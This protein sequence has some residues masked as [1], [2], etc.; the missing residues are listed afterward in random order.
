MKA[1]SKTSLLQHILLVGILQVLFACAS[2]HLFQQWDTRLK[3]M[4]EAP[5]K[6]NRFYTQQ[7][8]SLLLGS[9]PMKC[10]RLPSATPK[11]GIYLAGDQPTIKFVVPDSPASAAGIEPG[12]VVRSVNG[13]PTT[14]GQAVIKALEG[15]A[16]V[17]QIITI[18]TDLGLFEVSPTEPELEQCYWNVRYGPVARSAGA[19]TWGG[20][21]GSAAAGSA[22]Y[23]RFYKVTCRFENGILITFRSNWQ[24]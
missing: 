3:H 16:R 7:D 6:E 23:D 19:A 11:I 2:Q 12:L 24:M 20:Y 13:S 18:E 8:V 17:G 21:G 22:A 5:L 9:P 15:A 14:S 1:A 4:T 10:E